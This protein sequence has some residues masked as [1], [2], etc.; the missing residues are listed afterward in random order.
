MRDLLL[1]IIH[2]S[3]FLPGDFV[4][5]KEQAEEITNLFVKYFDVKIQDI[6]QYRYPYTPIIMFGYRNKYS[7]VCNDYDGFT[8][9]HIPNQYGDDPSGW[10]L[11]HS[12]MNRNKP[13]FVSEELS[14]SEIERAL[15]TLKMMEVIET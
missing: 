4:F 10:A 1:P 8:I 2:Q 12:T 7:F 14:V 13:A 11:P 9:C 15:K 6:T 5:T 3:H